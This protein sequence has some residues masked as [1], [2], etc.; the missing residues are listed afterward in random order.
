VR[1]QLDGVLWPRDDERG[2]AERP[3]VILEVQMHPDQGFRRRL[4][5]ES[6][7]FLQPLL[8]QRFL[9]QDGTWVDSALLPQDPGAAAGAAGA[10]PAYGQSN[11]SP[12]SVTTRSW[13]PSA[14]LATA[15]A[16]P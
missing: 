11:D 6:F 4:G 10:D 5:A 15:G 16:I 1:H 12:D 8:L 7:R 9:A 2:S 14:F 13:P 3:V